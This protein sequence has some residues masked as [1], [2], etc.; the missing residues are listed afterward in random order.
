LT[1]ARIDKARSSPNCFIAALHFS[2]IRM[3][4]ESAGSKSPF[5]SS[6][7]MITAPVLLIGGRQAAY[8][9]RSV[10]WSVSVA[11]AAGKSGSR[12]G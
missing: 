7:A 5:A 4:F 10:R 12:S 9:A 3:G 1:A 11:A 6:D 8:A 2:Q